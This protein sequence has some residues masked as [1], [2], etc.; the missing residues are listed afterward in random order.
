MK[1][2]KLTAENVKR[3]QAVEI[4]P[5]GNMVEVTG[6]NRQGKSSILDSIIM[7]FEG[8]SAIPS[9]PIRTGADKAQIILNIGDTG[10]PDKQLIITRKFRRTTDN[11]GA[12]KIL[13]EVYVEAANGARFKSPQAMLDALYGAMSFDPY[14]FTQRKPAEQFEQLK[15]FVPGVDFAAIDG[16]NLRDYEKRR[17]I[18]RDAKKARDGAAV[19]IVPPGTPEAPIDEAGLVR[20]LAAAGEHNAQIEAR[21]IRDRNLQEQAETDRR[22]A[23]QVRDELPAQVAEAERH[24]D[25]KVANLRQQ[26]EAIERIASADIERLSQAAATRADNAEASAREIDAELA[27]HSNQHLPSPIDIAALQEQINQARTTNANVTKA[28]E[29]SRLARDA[30]RLEAEAQALTD[31]IAAREK[32]KAEA[33]AGGNLPVP[34]LGFGKDAKGGPIVTLNGLP[35]DQASDA[36]QL[37]TSIAIAMGQNPKLRTILV[38]DGNGMDPEAM[39]ELARMAT[40]ADC[41]IFIETVRSDG[42]MAFVIEDGRVK[43]ESDKATTDD[44]DPVPVADKLL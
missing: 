24:R 42:R 22:T 20:T 30:A 27:E 29:K 6:K 41:Q 28:A 8:A 2:I 33:I 3:I 9:E 21:R 17:D 39:A 36:E 35:F 15:R 13:T 23:A 4:S 7:A 12:A 5:N 31:A 34:G 10:E 25:E 18:N 44:A 26:I 38:R 11:D 43:A 32:N 14:D 37:R 16:A 19:I 40:E 1:I